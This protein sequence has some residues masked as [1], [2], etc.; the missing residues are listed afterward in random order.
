M[1]EGSVPRRYARALFE[2][3]MEAGI[4]DRLGGD[5][6]RFVALTR[7]GDGALGAVMANPVYAKSERARVL[8]QVLPRLALHALTTSFLRLLLEKDRMALVGDILREYQA[9]ADRQA[10]RVRASVATAF[11]LTPAMRD[12]VSR[13]LTAA[14]GKQVVLETTVD[15]SLLGG[16][17]ARV[18]STLYDASLRTRLDRL[19]LSLST[20][21][22]A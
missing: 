16:I 12:D 22:R 21:A 20:P 6:E 14:T 11:E 19:Q 9:I 18:G 2:L 10:N 7:L 1:T 17:V 15:P 3:G 8:E 5:L 13:A 4:P